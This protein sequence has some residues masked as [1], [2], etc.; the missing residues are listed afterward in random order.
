MGDIKKESRKENILITYC[1]RCGVRMLAKPSPS[2][3][4]NNVCEDCI[5]GNNKPRHRAADSS[6]IPYVEVPS[7][8]DVMR[9]IRQNVRSRKS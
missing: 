3:E 1:D 2:G 6:Q 5:A 7:D 9:D 8:D 4:L